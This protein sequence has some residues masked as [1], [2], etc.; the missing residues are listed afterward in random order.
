[1]NQKREEW[2]MVDYPGYFAHEQRV[3]VL[4]KYKSKVLGCKMIHFR[5]RYK[6]GDV[7]IALPSRHLRKA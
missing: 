2:M 4:G 5:A 7:D 6:K 3:R 1:M